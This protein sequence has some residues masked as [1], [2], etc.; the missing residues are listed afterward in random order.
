[1]ILTYNQLDSAC[2]STLVTPIGYQPS[3]VVALQILY[4]IGCRPTE[5][6]EVHNW[7]DYSD[8]QV[9]MVTIKRGGMRYIDKS[10]LPVEF[11]NSLEMGLWYFNLVRISQLYN[12]FLKTWPYP[13][14]SV[15]NKDVKLYAFRYR[16]V[17][18]LV[19]EGYSEAQIQEIMGWGTQTLVGRYNG[20]IIEV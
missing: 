17:K 8:S 4:A 3:L 20:A 1:M 7:E 18:F 12:S 2:L 5:V 13:Q 6:F 14:A 16:Y 15:G 11:V 19:R 10:V 9:R